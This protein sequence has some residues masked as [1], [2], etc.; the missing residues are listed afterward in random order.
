MNDDLIDL[1][2]YGT[3]SLGRS[4]AWG[5]QSS[6]D[7][8]GNTHVHGLLWTVP[9]LYTGARRGDA[10]M[11]QRMFDL[12]SDWRADHR[13]KKTRT[14]SVTQPIIAGER[15]WTLTC[16]S[17]ISNGARFVAAT[18]AEAD[19]Q[20]ARFRLTGSNN[21]MIHSQGAALAAYCYLGDAAG[22]GR[23]AANLAKL[24]DYLVLPDGSDR[25]GSPWYAHYTLQ[26]LRRLEQVYS[27]CAV[28][29]DR[30]AAARGRLESFL[31]HAIDPDFRLV[32]NGDTHRGYLSPSAFP[33]TSVGRWAATRGTEGVPPTQLYRSFQGGYVFARN[34]WLDVDGHRPTFYSVR[35]SR[36]PSPTVHTHNDRGTVTF[37]SHGTE[38]I[39]DPGPY[40]YEN[41]G[42]RS[43][44][45]GRSA[46]SLVRITERPKKKSKRK[47]RR[48][49]TALP[50]VALPTV[51][52]PS[53]VLSAEPLPSQ[54]TCLSDGTYPAAT[55]TRCVYYDAGVDAL[56]IVDQIAAHARVRAD[57][58]WQ[59]SPGVGVETRRRGALL[60]SASA[61][62][63]V[64]FRGGG[65]VR[66]LRP[67]SGRHDGWFTWGYGELVKGAV[68]QRGALLGKGGTRTW[69]TVI[70]AGQQTPS[71]R[72]SADT[73]TVSRHGV[74]ASF[75]LPR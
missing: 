41:S 26:L 3:Y 46:H 17:D 24:A 45:V 74:A 62:A 49:A 60:N 30:I 35:T 57:Q 58:R 5:R 31:A 16:A 65:S 52:S 21:T 50:A 18:S 55:I 22:R 28:P 38:W 39:G 75:T 14:W 43:Y 53:R 2:Q 67:G 12:I 9:L 48:R 44:L 66:T 47:A 4:P 56:V 59:I 63:R 51:P 32:M 69:T 7:S 37:H 11:V 61:R 71:V 1:G 29:Y 33:A 40:R 70:A 8:S 36:G 20:V 25:E 19:R 73:V 54:K 68:L 34:S 23:A 15:L 6:A 72:W 27:R 42:L 64:A 13:K 10:A